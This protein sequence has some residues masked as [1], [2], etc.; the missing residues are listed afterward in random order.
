LPGAASC[1]LFALPGAASR[2]GAGRVMAFRIGQNV[3]CV[4]DAIP[5]GG[6]VY[7]KRLRCS[8]RLLGDLDGL[9]R[10]AIYTV[11][12]IDLD[13]ADELPVLFL[14]EI[15]RP[16]FHSEQA[17]TGFDQR[18]FRPLA[19]RNKQTSIAVFEALLRPQEVAT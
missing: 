17:E 12:G 11:R 1:G 9:K 4:D 14:E 10:G 7:S 5:H 13:W 15:V 3:V 6:T 19:E 18:R 16:P 8:F 2:A